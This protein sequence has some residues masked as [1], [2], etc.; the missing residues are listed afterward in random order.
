MGFSSRCHSREPSRN[1]CSKR[2][3]ACAL[4]SK[5]ARSLARAGWVRDAAHA[6]ISRP[7]GNNQ[8]SPAFLVGVPADTNQAGLGSGRDITQCPQPNDPDARKTAPGHFVSV[9]AACFS[10]GVS[11]SRVS[12]LLCRTVLTSQRSSCTLAVGR[13]PVVVSRKRRADRRTTV[14]SAA[15]GATVNACSCL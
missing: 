5:L 9:G 15:G 13:S 4:C 8:P 6:V 10:C 12:D 14:G 2:W 3:P 11:T 7:A 1:A